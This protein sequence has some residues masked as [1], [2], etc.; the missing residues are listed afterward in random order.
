[1]RA[2]TLEEIVVTGTKTRHRVDDAP[3]PTQVITREQILATSPANVAQ[4][5][6]EVPDIY[7]RT[8]DQ[9]RLGA[10]TV[11]MQGADPN[12]VA[13]L[14]NGRRF[15]GGIDGVV[16]LRDIPV[17]NIER[18][19]IIRGPA[20]SLYGSDAMAGV[21]NV[22][23]RTG[24]EAPSFNVTAGGGSFDRILVNA[25]HGYR[26]GPLG[27]FLS[28]QHDEIAIAQQYGEISAQFAGDESDAKQIR[29][30]VAADF[31]Y[32]AGTRHRLT[33]GANYNPIQEG[34][35]SEKD[36]ISA[37]GGW[38]WQ[39][40]PTTDAG[41]N[42]NRYSFARTNDLPGFQENVS[43]VDWE[44]EVRASSLLTRGVWSEQHLGTLGLQIRSESIDLAPSIRSEGT[45]VFETPAVRESVYQNSPY[46]QDEI[47]L[48]ESWSTVIGASIDVNEIYGAHVSPRLSVTWRPADWLR[49]TGTVGR[50][51]RAPDLLQ[52]YDIDANSIVLV[53]NRVTGYVILGNPNLQPETDLGATIQIETRPLPGSIAN[54]SLYRHDFRDLI[55][56]S[57][58]CPGPMLCKPGFVSPYPDLFGQVFQ[59]ENVGAAITQG[60]DVSVGVEALRFLPWRLPDHY[61][62]IDLA[63]G[64]LYSRNESGLAGEDGK[65][66]PF[67]PPNRFLPSLTYRQGQCG[68]QGKFWGEYE[69]RTFSDT[70]NSYEFI[71][72][73]HWLWNFRVE[74]Q[75]ARW[76][77]TPLVRDWAQSAFAGVTA[78]V[79]GLNILDDEF[80]IPTPMGNVAGRRTFL[81]GLSYEW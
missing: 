58:A 40:A 50:G 59:Y 72:Q 29:D 32:Q 16:D 41:L 19:E 67:R 39:I 28:Y 53:R 54:L 4:V 42:L 79:D 47:S 11:R 57:L 18:I 70:T 26:V 74:G 55:A 13:I 21:I 9:F 6:D 20:S 61:V 44:G 5:L 69:D 8:N 45:L 2:L 78:F 10:S 25:S 22:I 48:T 35:L 60:F 65:E 52:L 56:V 33:A 73:S 23:T 30:N 68:V 24:T 80:G 1:M 14:L 63:Y 17:N 46:L 62:R 75:P 27:Y 12:K 76:L 3:I 15:R 7:V 64:Y 43:Y 71:I 34:P 31:D 38:D 66:L 49:V 77:T 36:N 51:F 81:A 37:Y